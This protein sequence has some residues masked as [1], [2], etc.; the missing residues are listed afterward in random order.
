MGAGGH[1]SGVCWGPPTLTK[2]SRVGA[3]REEVES[4]SPGSSHSSR[5]VE[6]PGFY[7]HQFGRWKK[8]L[9]LVEKN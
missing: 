7:T 2:N 4:G 6:S 5:Q 8:M 3:G 9:N 1:A